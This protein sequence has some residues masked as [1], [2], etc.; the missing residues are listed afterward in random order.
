V[1]ATQGLKQ[2]A[3]ELI[4]SGT[5]NPRWIDLARIIHMPGIRDTLRIS[6]PKR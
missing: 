1:A 4:L 6:S 2:T 3:K 5:Q